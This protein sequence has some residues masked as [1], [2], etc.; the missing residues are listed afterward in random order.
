MSAKPNSEGR[1]LAYQL[2]SLDINTV[3]DTPAAN[4]DG[5]TRRDPPGIKAPSMPLMVQDLAENYRWFSG[6]GDKAHFSQ[7]KKAADETLKQRTH[8]PQHG[9]LD[10]V[11]RNSGELH[12]ILDTAGGTVTDDGRVELDESK[13]TPAQAATIRKAWELALDPIDLA[14]NV[15]LKGDVVTRFS[16][17]G[18]TPPSDAVVAFHGQMVAASLTHW[19]AL[20]GVLTTFLG[21][22]A[23]LLPG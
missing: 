19:A 2:V 22:L 20:I 6:A 3:I 7:V 21:T 14:T 16:S 15:S 23:R 5:I 13:L 10:R 12:D 11:A 4:R 8:H 18:G 9:L 1:R 17:R